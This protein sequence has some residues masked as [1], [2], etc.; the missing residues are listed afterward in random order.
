MFG[1]ILI[2]L[3]QNKARRKKIILAIIGAIVLAI[4]IG[5]IVHSARN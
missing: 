3:F 5:V 2:V 4:I 1:N